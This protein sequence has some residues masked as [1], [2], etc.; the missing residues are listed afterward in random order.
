MAAKQPA[1]KSAKKPAKK[2]AKAKSAIRR[3]E[4]GARMSSAVVHEGRV[5]LSGAVAEKT[6]GK[7]V[8]LQTREILAEI[9]RV[10]KLAGTDKT[11]VLAANIYLADMKTFGEMNK[12]WDCWVAKGHAPAR[13]TV[14]AK[15]A[16]PEYTVEIMVTAAL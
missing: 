10:L 2:A 8:T 15:L 7:S 13:A 6:V 9:D 12:V 4:P 16:G 3:I 11:R 14:E 1:T 5:Y